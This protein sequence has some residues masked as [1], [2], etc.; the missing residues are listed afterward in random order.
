MS[1]FD[2]EYDN[3]GFVTVSFVLVV[4][5]HLDSTTDCKLVDFMVMP[6]LI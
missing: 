2:E 1:L 4:L 6:T 3:N 5:T